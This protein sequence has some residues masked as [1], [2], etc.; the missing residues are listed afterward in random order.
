LSDAQRIDSLSHALQTSHEDIRRLTTHLTEVSRR[1]KFL[2]KLRVDHIRRLESIAEEL[3][4]M[5]SSVDRVAEIL[6]D[7]AA[8]DDGL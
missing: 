5:Q 7:S 8:E 1:R 2:E 6:Q 3:R 4:V